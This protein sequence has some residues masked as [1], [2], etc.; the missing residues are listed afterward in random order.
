MNQ[1]FSCFEL[2][3][4]DDGSTDG[5]R[6]IIKSYQDTRIRLIANEHDFI[7]SLNLLLEH[8]RGKYIARMDADDRMMQDRLLW[9]YEY[10]EAHPEVDVLGGGM[11]LFGTS[12]GNSIPS[13]TNEPL[14]FLD[15]LNGNQLANPTTMLRRSTLEKH[16]LRYEK[17]ESV[18]SQ[19]YRLWMRMLQLNLHLENLPD[20]LVEYRVSD[21][22]V[23]NAHREE[24]QAAFKRTQTKIKLW[25][26]E[27]EQKHVPDEWTVIPQSG[28][29]LTLIIPFLNEG[30]EVIN[31]VHSIRQYAGYSVDILVINDHSYDGYDYYGKLSP[32]RVHY[33]Y[34]AERKGVAASRDFGVRLC[35]TPYF[36]LLDAHM[37]F[38]DGQWVQ[39]ITQ[40][41]EENDRCVLCC[42]TKTLNKDS[43]GRVFEKR[44]VPV[45][46]GA[47]IPFMK[48]NYL[49]DIKWR[50]KEDYPGEAIEPIPAIL[51]A[52]YAASK[53]YWTYLRGLEG[54]CLYGCDEAYLSLKVWLEGGQCL[55]L[56][57]VVI[58]HIYRT[59]S[60]YIVPSAEFV[61]NY[62]FISFLLFPE[63][64]RILSFSIARCIDRKTFDEAILLLSAQSRLLNELR[65]YY[66]TIC[67]RPFDEIL[68]R[69]RCLNAEQMKDVRSKRELL[70]SIADF[71]CQKK[72]SS[73][74][75]IVDGTMNEVLFFFHYARFTH[76][77]RWE[78]HARALLRQVLTS[79]GSQSLPIDFKDGLCGIGWGLIYLEQQGFV[80][81]ADIEE[82]LSGIDRILLKTDIAAINTSSFLQGIGGFM[83][84][85]V[86]RVL[87][88]NRQHQE[89]PLN[90][91]QMESIAAKAKDVLQQSNNVFMV[92]AASQFQYIME[93][94]SGLDAF[95]YTPSI[96]DWT[97][98]PTFLPKN[99]QYWK[100]GMSGCSG[101]GLLT[102]LIS[103]FNK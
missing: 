32:Y 93:H 103:N 64:L 72:P 68:D 3:I 97:N 87:F 21:T 67:T 65:D 57:E 33:F 38:Y 19:D 81:T 11:R 14:N 95:C 15:M 50:N 73:E 62:L 7:S 92:N 54:L 23:G 59:N 22:Q 102:M 100:P 61:Y 77:E 71:L 43:K 44:N 34:N 27:R 86:T 82:T 6:G 91:K 51:G 10:M 40:L 2:L 79:I 42:Q 99:P 58:G 1:S 56:K 55:L 76:E 47:Y 41:L 48:N 35:S 69:N 16:H 9:Q 101:V 26:A 96:H 70:P 85:W 74:V 90:R 39:T 36:L 88:S 12:V 94:T 60:P 17:D 52:G 78:T 46:Y 24:Q 75:G 89:I 80:A 4:V 31:T 18:Y 53:R 84:Y 66:R 29:R 63:P 13:K 25:L 49:P 45:P 8:A 83:W 30:D 5:S 98:F 20:I 37:R 28:N